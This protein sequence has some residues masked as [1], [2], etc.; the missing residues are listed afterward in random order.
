MNRFL[1]WSNKWF[2]FVLRIAAFLF[3]L[4]FTIVITI[5]RLRP[6]FFHSSY[7]FPVGGGG[8]GEFWRITKE[9]DNIFSRNFFYFSQHGLAHNL[10]ANDRG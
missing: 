4:F 8:G 7:P 9:Q 5:G 6:S 3:S 1:A 2:L 10:D